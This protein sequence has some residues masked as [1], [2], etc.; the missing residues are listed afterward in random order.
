[1][2]CRSAARAP[3]SVECLVLGTRISASRDFYLSRCSLGAEAIVSSR[4]L[5]MNDL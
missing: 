4:F 1:M 5:M 3:K 2:R